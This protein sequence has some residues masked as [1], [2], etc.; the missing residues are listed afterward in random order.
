MV[1]GLVAGSGWLGRGAG[2]VFASRTSG[3]GARRR[4]VAR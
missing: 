2:G 4:A 1:R 3:A